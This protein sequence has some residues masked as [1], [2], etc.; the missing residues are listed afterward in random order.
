MTNSDLG[1]LRPRSIVVDAHVVDAHAE[2]D[3]R[4]SPAAHA[5]RKMPKLSIPNPQLKLDP[6]ALRGALS[7]L[8][9]DPP[10]AAVVRAERAPRSSAWTSSP[11]TWRRCRRA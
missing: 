4:P 10:V 1:L 5:K 6:R 11:A 9:G 3:A 2:P 7:S 8:Q